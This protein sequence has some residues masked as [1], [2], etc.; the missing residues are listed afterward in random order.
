MHLLSRC[1]R[2]LDNPLYE[3]RK[4][5]MCY[6]KR[7][8]QVAVLTALFVFSGLLVVN[9]GK[10][11]AAARHLILY[12]HCDDYYIEDSQ[13]KVRYHTRVVYID[14][15]SPQSKNRKNLISCLI[16]H[17]SVI[18]FMEVFETFSFYLQMLTVT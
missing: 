13:H 6:I 7:A 14:Q 17:V 4:P 5:M 3:K 10:D 16:A 9:T 8:A 2:T 12:E 18:F 15:V 11:A 1:Q